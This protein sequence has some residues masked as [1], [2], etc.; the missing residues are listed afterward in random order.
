MG[1]SEIREIIKKIFW[2]NLKDTCIFVIKH[3]ENNVEKLKEI[4]GSV[5]DGY[6]TH[7]IITLDGTY[8]PLH[9]IIEIKRTNGTIVWSKMKR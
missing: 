3:R 8:I 2:L 9:R 5:I 1:R 6:T 4:P 7:Y